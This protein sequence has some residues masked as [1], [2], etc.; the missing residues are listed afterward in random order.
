VFEYVKINECLLK[1]SIFLNDDDD[2]DDDD[3]HTYTIHT[4]KFMMHPT[5]QFASKSGALRWHQKQLRIAR[6]KQYSYKPVLKG[7][8]P[9]R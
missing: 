2:D 5:C 3:E 9:Q 8:L 1:M 4:N 6:F 7:V